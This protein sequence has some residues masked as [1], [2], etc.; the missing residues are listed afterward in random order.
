M[1]QFNKFKNTCGFIANY[2]YILR[3]R[4]MDEEAKKRVKII[5]HLNLFGLEST[6]DAFA[7]SK[8]SIYRWKKILEYNPR[9]LKALN[10]ISTAPHKR[11]KMAVDI[12]LEQEIIRLR[13]MNPCIGKTQIYHQIKYKYKTSESTVGRYIKYLKE[14]NKLPLRGQKLY[15]PK[16]SIVRQRRKQKTGFEIDTIVRYVNNIKWYFV[17]AINIDTRKAYAF[18]TL[19]HTSKS[20]LPIFKSIDIPIT[21]I[22][23][24]NG[25]E[26]LDLFHSYCVGNSIDHYFIYPRSPK[27]NIYV[28][29]FNR[30]LS[31]EFIRWNKQPM[32]DRLNIDKIQKKL[33]DYMYYYNNIRPHTSL[34]FLSPMM[35]IKKQESQM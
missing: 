6:K 26:F 31:E 14:H 16:K 21:Q 5:N 18:V 23:T 25:S 27:M 30:T 12:N 20:S 32:V 29:R 19:S 10:K 1:H 33:D 4:N 9:N 2:S 15:K 22:Q 35:Y 28:E 24:D 11:R 3:I 13:T 17:T 7:V 8:A 34:G